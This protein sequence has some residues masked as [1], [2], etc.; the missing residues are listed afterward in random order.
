MKAT[1]KE[2]RIRIGIEGQA[3]GLGKTGKKGF[4]AFVPGMGDIW[5]NVT[6]NKTEVR[7]AQGKYDVYEVDAV[8]KTGAA[9]KCWY[10][11]ALS[12]ESFNDSLALLQAQQAARKA[13]HALLSVEDAIG[14]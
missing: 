2:A 3:I 14:A 7:L 5:I 8:D 13:E 6:K 4:M 10:Y 1:G 12:D 11:G 9:Y